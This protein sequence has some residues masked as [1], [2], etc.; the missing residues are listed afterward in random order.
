MR[1][2][3]LTQPYPLDTRGIQHIYRFDNGYGASVIQAPSLPKYRKGKWE[4]SVVRFSG[5]PD[6]LM[7]DVDKSTPVTN[8]YFAYLS[9]AGVDEVL[10]EIE[11][12]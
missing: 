4:L 8:S 5:L 2:A 12:L 1:K 9:D 7:W 3:T 10:S 6:L 11:K